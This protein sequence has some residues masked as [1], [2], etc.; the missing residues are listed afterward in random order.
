MGQRLPGLLVSVRSVAEAQAALAGGAD[1]IDVKEP[2]RG[3][4][5]AADFAVVE[6]V[7]AE[8]AGRAPVSVANGEWAKTDGIRMFAGVSFVKWG[9]AGLKQ[10]ARSAA[11]AIRRCPPPARPVLV[12]YA[13]FQRAQS[14]PPSDLVALAVELQFPALL[15]FCCV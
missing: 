4:L 3:P 9:L 11:D 2:D 1:L 5:G 10:P 13:D 12:A 7:V 14:P 8:V 15:I 6:A